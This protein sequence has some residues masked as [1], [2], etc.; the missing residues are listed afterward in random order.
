LAIGA[1]LALAQDMRTLALAS[2]LLFAACSPPDSAVEGTESNV[3]SKGDSAIKE[4]PSLRMTGK[5]AGYG[6]TNL[7]IKA[8]SANTYDVS[9]K[10]FGYNMEYTVALE[11]DGFHA[12]GSIVGY[13]VSVV[14]WNYPD[15]VYRLNGESGGYDLDLW[16]KPGANHTY[17]VT[18]ENNGYDADLT[19][20]GSGQ[21]YAVNGDNLSY[22]TNLTVAGA[23]LDRSSLPVPVL[24]ALGTCV[25]VKG[26][27]W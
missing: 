3:E 21:S 18:G 7:A 20:S 15:G 11:W 2:M 5:N 16:V 17:R 12:R 8:T 1:L 22:T 27:H 25:G 6:E 13:D 24:L 10:N 9:G 26:S 23:A 19:I 14:V 4:L